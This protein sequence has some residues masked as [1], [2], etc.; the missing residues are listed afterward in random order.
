LKKEGEK[1]SEFE[2]SPIDNLCE[3]CFEK[4]VCK[5]YTKGVASEECDSHKEIW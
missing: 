5:Y 3:Y 2:F 4:E 1:M